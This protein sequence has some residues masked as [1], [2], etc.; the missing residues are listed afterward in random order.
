MQQ[1]IS[2]YFEIVLNDS[3]NPC[4]VFDIETHEIIFQ[5]YAMKKLLKD[6]RGY[7]KD[8]PNERCYEQ[9][10]QRE[11]PCDLCPNPLLEVNSFFESNTYNPVLQKNFRVQST[12]FEVKGRS[13]NISKYFVTS[14]Y[15]NQVDSF[16]EALTQGLQIFSGKHTFEQMTSS[17]LALIAQFYLSDL[18]HVIYFDHSRT[19]VSRQF[20]WGRED[21]YDLDK[22]LQKQSLETLLSWL[23]PCARGSIVNIDPRAE[24]YRP[25]QE[26]VNLLDLFEVNN[27]SMC[28]L[29]DDENRCVGTVA[30]CDR[31]DSSFDPRLLH[32]VSSFIQDGFSKTDMQEQ[33]QTISETDYLT[34][35]YSR[36][37]YATML[38]SFDSSPPPQLGAVFVNINGLRKTNEYMGFLKGDQLIASTALTLSEFFAEPFYRISGDEFVCFCH[39]PN[40]QFFRDKVTHMITTLRARHDH[41]FAVG[42]AWHSG[43]VDAEHLVSE[44]DTAMY[45]DKQT[46]YKNNRNLR[47]N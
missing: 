42:C 36:T 38:L 7:V 18:C 29:Y 13:Y 34:G 5:N 39:E 40:E 25:T 19:Q 14:S 26:Y 31:R 35:F 24:G 22:M 6:A 47:K 46:H 21:T 2:N 20:Q 37:K 23:E 11:S 1:T 27:L 30:L 10:F 8:D 43:S 4:S 33:L 15:S 44:A 45:K 9:M 32:T 16:N 17:F 28:L 41:S 12:K 3:S